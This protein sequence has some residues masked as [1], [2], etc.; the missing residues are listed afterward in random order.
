MAR[1]SN[2][3]PQTGPQAAL[4]RRNFLVAAGALGLTAPQGQAEPKAAVPGPDDLTGNGEWLYRVAPGWGHLPAGTEFGGTHG[5]ITADQAGLVYVST[6]S[7]TGI[8][9]Y[10][11]DGTLVRTIVPQYPEVHSMVYTIENG[12][13]HIY[14][15][16]Q[17]GTPEENWLFVKLK[18]DGTVVQKI[19]APPEAGFTAP[20]AWRLTAAVP[21]PDGSIWIANGYGDSRIFHF[22]SKGAYIESI[23]GK[24]STE[25]LLDCSHGLTLDTRYD[26]PLLLVCDR[27]NRRLCHFDLDGKYVETVTRHLRRPCQA[28]IHGDFL[29]VSEL[30]GRVTILDRDN[31]PVA[32]LGDN[33]QKAQWAN[34]GIDPGQIAAA[35]FSAAHG[36]FVDKDAN[37]YISDW[38]H[39]GRVTKLVRVAA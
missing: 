8:L 15:T 31:V 22:D 9:V 21:A 25:G 27:E 39:V 14:A 38:N 10:R 5:G 2:R 32:F 20:N 28:S 16:V 37:I 4:T 33:P 30:E 18:T 1:I 17:K 26:Q 36:C 6:Q 3:T 24:G 34:Y 13:E 7:T 19:T 29:V 11:A 23:S 35:A 12:E